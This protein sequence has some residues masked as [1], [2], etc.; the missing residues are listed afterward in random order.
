MCISPGAAASTGD[1]LSS[2][3]W[4]AGN[5]WAM[6]TDSEAGRLGDLDPAIQKLEFKV[7][8]LPPEEPQVQA[9]LRSAAVVPAQRKSDFYD[10]PEFALFA[11]DLV[12]RAR[13]DGRRR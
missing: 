2:V 5:R 11:K 10:T 3:A 6:A 8:V 7:T 12:L 1:N 4:R 13:G 9:E